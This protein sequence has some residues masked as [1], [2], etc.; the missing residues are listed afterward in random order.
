MGGRLVR[1][2][3][4]VRFAAEGG[5]CDLDGLYVLGDTQHVDNH[6]TVDHAVPRCTSQQLYK[7]VLAGF[8]RAVFNGRILVRQDAQKTDARQ[9]NK[10]LLLTDG[11]EVYSKPQLEIFADDVRCTHGAAEGQLAEDAMFYFRSRGLRE[12]TARI[13]LTHGFASEVIGRITEEPIG[14][15]LDRL[16]L[17]RLQAGLAVETPA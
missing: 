4:G 8:S 1:N 6:V 9:T 15:H 3:L 11:P 13:L 7:G 10:T 12:E 5:T 14:R 17:A 2:T 16:V